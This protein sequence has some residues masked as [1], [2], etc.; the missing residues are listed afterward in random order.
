MPTKSEVIVNSFLAIYELGCIDFTNLKMIN[1]A[2]LDEKI[3][4]KFFKFEDND[5]YLEEAHLLTE[6]NKNLYKFESKL[7]FK[8][9]IDKDL[10][11]FIKF[12]SKHVI[13]LNCLQQLPMEKV[14]N[15]SDV[16]DN[17]NWQAYQ[18][19]DFID[20]KTYLDYKL[21]NKLD[22]NPNVNILIGGLSN[23]KCQPAISSIDKYY[24]DQFNAPFIP[25]EDAK[26][27]IK[28]SNILKT[29]KFNFK[30]V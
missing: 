12:A 5:Y 20:K 10:I 26:E 25:K 16:F 4:A 14:I 15:V 30:L 29:G 19:L 3:I 24:T 1:F 18:D 23:E 7:N 13:D 28:N 8:D 2:D 9:D 6:L 17:F 11:R 22:L 21:F 27:L